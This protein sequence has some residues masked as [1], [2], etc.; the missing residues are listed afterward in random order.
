MLDTFTSSHMLQNKIL[1][2]HYSYL[3]SYINVN[4]SHTK[5]ILQTN[6]LTK[7]PIIIT[8]LRLVDD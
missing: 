6:A 4:I 8:L 1:Y 7:Y 2:H 5:K 3:V